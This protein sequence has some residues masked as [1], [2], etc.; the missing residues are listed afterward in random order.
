MRGFDEVDHYEAL[1]VSRDASHAEIERAYRMLLA[2]YGTDSLATYSMFGEDE[3]A[4]MRDRIEAAYRVLSDAELRRSY[5][6][7]QATEPAAADAPAE[8]EPVVL[9]P[10]A[11]AALA[12]PLVETRAREAP[13]FERIADEEDSTEESAWDG[14]RLRRARLQRGIEIDDLAAATKITPAYL[15][16]LEEERFDDLPAVVYVRGFIASYA[17]YLGLDAQHVARSYAARCEEHRHAK[18]KGR[19]LG[20]R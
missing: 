3:S 11:E 14:A 5:D 15:R 9:A 18:P 16:F 17:R 19:L 6:A 4:S 1:E 12:K 13:A 7:A 20:R 10:L 8:D 2:T